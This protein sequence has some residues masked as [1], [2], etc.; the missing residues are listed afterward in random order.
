MPTELRDLLETIDA[1]PP[2]SGFRERV[3][4]I[5][6]DRDNR[7]RRA[8]L[9][10]AAVGA[11]AVAALSA[12]AVLGFGAASGASG[13]YDK[14]FACPVPVIGGVPVFNFEADGPSSS[15]SGGLQ[16]TLPAYVGAP[17]RL[18]GA[19]GSH[20]GGVSVDTKACA[21]APRIPL[22]RGNLHSLGSF[23]RNDG[24]DYGDGDRCFSGATIVFRL[25]AAL[26]NGSVERAQFAVRTGA[27]PHPFLYVSWTGAKT[28]VWGSDACGPGP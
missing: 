19:Y 23:G 7:A 28:Q 3:Y 25:R 13:T 15:S 20:P 11:V 17:R 5:A 4:E 12:T 16:I 6:A 2:R 10:L 24:L 18:V 1:P 14:T 9:L 21:P 8:R 22:Q 27:H 26:N